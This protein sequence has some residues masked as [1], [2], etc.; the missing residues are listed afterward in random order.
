MEAQQISNEKR[1]NAKGIRYPMYDLEDAYNVA[2]QINRLGGGKIDIN[3]LAQGMSYTPSTTMHHVSSA[4]HYNLVVQEKDM[5]I[6]TELAKHLCM[7]LS[8]DEKAQNLRKAF[9]SLTI[10]TTLYERFKGGIVPEE[11][12]LS[13]LLHREFGVSVTG[14]DVLARN[15]ISSLKFSNLGDATSD[16]KLIIHSEE[17]EK[18]LNSEEEK[19]IEIKSPTIEQDNPKIED[20]IILNKNIVV[21]NEVEKYTTK[22]LF[23]QID[24]TNVLAIS[25]GIKFLEMLKQLQDDKI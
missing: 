15:F 1:T 13:N 4:K 22:G 2:M 17:L 11:S 12:T 19:L 9:F 24:P 23:L 5:V 10:Y 3:V 20:N 16:G 21:G 8:S 6:N 14:K 25:K 7:P 18:E